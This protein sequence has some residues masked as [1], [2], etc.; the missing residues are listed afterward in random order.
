M[1]LFAAVYPAPEAVRD[2]TEV[3]DGLAVGAR[4][5]AGVDVR[6]SPP[7]QWH[8]TVAF[9][10][11]VPDDR[12][13]RVTVALREAVESWQVERAA[14]PTLR[15]A[16]GGCFGQ[17]ASTVLWAGLHGDV[18][19]LTALA[20]NV[21]RHLRGAGLPTDAKPFRPHLTLARPGDRLGHDEIEADL[22]LL[23]AHAGPAWT[24]SE[25][26]L[27]RSHFPQRGYEKLAVLPLG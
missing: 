26:A 23:S 20:S 27:V 5:A 16:D 2:L 19:S 11:E 12:L 6:L 4:Q 3:V 13:P 21:N 17:G 8:V 9:L 1:R 25:L 10:G 14:Q 22:A 15:I 7:D 18:G 24:V